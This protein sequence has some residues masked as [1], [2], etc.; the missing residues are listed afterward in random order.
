MSSFHAEG[1]SKRRSEL[2]GWP[3]GITCYSVQDH[4]V[5]LIDNVDPGATIARAE[6]DTAEA[7]ERE[8]LN[9]A[10]ERLSATALRRRS[11]AELHESVAKLDEAV[12]SKRSR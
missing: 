6:A 4:W 3:I 11:L 8:A 9:I 12:R 7:A 1:Y 5:A 10:R 2:E